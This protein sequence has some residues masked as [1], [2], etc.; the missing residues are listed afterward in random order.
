MGND[1]KE[2]RRRMK[3]REDRR[4]RS[5][6]AVGCGKSGGGRCNEQL[7]RVGGGGGHSD[8]VGGNVAAQRDGS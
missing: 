1:E 4:G 3:K 6:M 7:K 2:S 5:T 8:N